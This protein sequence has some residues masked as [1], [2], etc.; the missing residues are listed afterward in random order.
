VSCWAAGCVDEVV[1]AL[2]EE[3]ADEDED[4]V[5]TDTAWSNRLP[6]ALVDAAL[7]VLGRP[8]RLRGRRYVVHTLSFGIPHPALCALCLFGKPRDRNPVI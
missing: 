5:G 8:P 6:P 4:A 3:R 2:G 1:G 7:L